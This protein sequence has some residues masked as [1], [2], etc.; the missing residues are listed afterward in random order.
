MGL[1]EVGTPG[2]GHS[3]GQHNSIQQ[4]FLFLRLIDLKVRV[5]S[6]MTAMARSFCVDSGP[7]DFLPLLSP[8]H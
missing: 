6:Q 5:P 3:L 8:D 2:T 7:K 1:I 4:L